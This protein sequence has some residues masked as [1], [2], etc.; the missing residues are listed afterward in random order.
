ML[1]L[2]A[3]PQSAAQAASIG[4]ISMNAARRL[5]LAIETQALLRG[6]AKGR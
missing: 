5:C 3:R 2:A 6:N 4:L 1:S